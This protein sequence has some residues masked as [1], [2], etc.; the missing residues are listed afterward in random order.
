MSATSY[1][2][3]PLFNSPII[4]HKLKKITYSV[5]FKSLYLDVMQCQGIKNGW[6]AN[7]ICWILGKIAVLKRG[8]IDLF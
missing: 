8:D 7:Y 2:S 1:T 6:D 5:F 4:N 3:L